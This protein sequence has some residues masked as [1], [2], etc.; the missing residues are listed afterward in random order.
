MKT[1]VV[2]LLVL[3]FSIISVQLNA[4]SGMDDIIYLKNGNTHRGLIIEQIPN[5]SYKI[6]TADGNIV[7]VAFAEVSKITKEPRVNS[8]PPQN[9]SYSAEERKEQRDSLRRQ[10]KYRN[11]GYFFQAQ[12]LIELIHG[13]A[14][15]INGY[16]FGQFG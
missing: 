9:Q 12:L 5:E 8:A 14:H 2:S 7:T 10:F 3:F 16:K 11:K 6:R 1:I 13:G 4:Q 15:I